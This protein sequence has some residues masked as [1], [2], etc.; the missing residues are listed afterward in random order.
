MK[1]T[2]ISPEAYFH[3]VGTQYV[4]AQLLFHLNQTSILSS[5][6]QKETV[7]LAEFCQ[8]LKLNEDVTTAVFDYLANVT[9]LFDFKNGY[10]SI[11]EFGREYLSRYGRKTDDGNVNMNFWD[12]SVG[13]YGNVWEAIHLLSTNKS[14]YGKDIKRKGEHAEGGVFKS[15]QNFWPAIES[16]TEMINDLDLIAELGVNSGLLKFLDDKN[17][18]IPLLGIDRNQAAIKKFSSIFPDLKKVSFVC[19][20]IVD[21]DKWSAG[22]NPEKPKLFYSIH[23]H[24]FMAHPETVVRFFKNIKSHFNKSYVLAFEQPRYREEERSQMPEH[25]WQYCYSNILIHDLIGNGKILYRDEW[26]K[27]FE[28]CGG[29]VIVHKPIGYL[30]YEMY[31][32]E[33]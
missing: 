10:I 3:D 1:T 18:V 22:I 4:V 14:V 12:V 19:Q 9:P 31:L 27:F 28:S 30:G 6:F 13:A 17:S 25:R 24:E 7:H 20:D 33:V 2:K 29:K 32:V 26:R 8:Q 21:V 23:F 16:A 15:A 5:V 11:T